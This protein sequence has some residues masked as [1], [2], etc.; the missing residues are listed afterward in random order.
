MKVYK[1]LVWYVVPLSLA[2]GMCVSCSLQVH[3]LP[4]DDDGAELGT[5]HMAAALC[6][7]LGPGGD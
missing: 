3:T 4:P 1:L 7:V 2:W 6:S 5:Q